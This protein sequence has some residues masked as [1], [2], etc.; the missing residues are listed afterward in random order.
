MDISKTYNGLL[1]AIKD[2]F[3][4][5]EGQTLAQFSQECAALSSTDKV[6]FKAEL[7]KAG[8]KFAA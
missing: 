2:Y 3:G 8:Y 7:A 1:S 6:W 5:L 4:F